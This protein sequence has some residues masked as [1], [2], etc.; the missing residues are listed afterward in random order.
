MPEEPPP[1]E[2]ALTLLIY[3]PLGFAMYARDT[4]PSLIGLFAARGRRELQ[5]NAKPVE[6]TV[7]HARTIGG[8]VLEAATAPDVRRR[9]EEGIDVARDVATGAFGSLLAWRTG[10]RPPR[11][12]APASTAPV[13]ENPRTEPDVPPATTWSAPPI[14][15]TSAAPSTVSPTAPVDTA[16]SSPSASSVPTRPGGLAIPDYDELSASQVVDRLEGLESSELDAIR[17]YEL[18]NRGRNTI[19]G[20]I[21]QLTS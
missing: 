1:V 12:E 3:A 6:R 7:E 20:K 18:A 9:V 2:K 17:R 11:P 14:S 15:H 19:L 13:D 5:T 4:L 21:A 10:E 16:P 8:T